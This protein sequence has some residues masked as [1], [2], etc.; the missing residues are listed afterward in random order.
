M[1]QALVNASRLDHT[2]ILGDVAKEYSQA[3]ILGI[4]VLQ[5]ANTTIGTIGI[6]RRI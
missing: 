4:G 5:V 2:A 3:A 6:E 1:P